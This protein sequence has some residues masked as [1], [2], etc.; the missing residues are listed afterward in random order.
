MSGTTTPSIVAIAGSCPTRDNFNSR[1]NPGYKRW[2]SCDLATNQT[3]MI[4]QMSPPVDITWQPLKK[5]NDYDVWNINS[6]LSRDF[7]TLVA[8][9]RP[10]YL[11][12]DFFADVH[13]GVV[14]LADGRFVTDNRWKIQYTDW[15]QE[16]WEQRGLTRLTMQ[17]DLEE[18]LELWRAAMDRFAAHLAE[19][20]PDTTVV[21]HRGWNTNLV[22][23]P[24]RPQPVLM[25]RHKKM[26]K[27]DAQLGNE[28]W[29][30]LDDYCLEKFGWQAIDLRGEGFTS[31]AEHPWGAFWVHYEPEYYHRFLAELHK[32]HVRRTATDADLPDRVEAIEDAARESADRRWRQAQALAASR[33][34]TVTEQRQRIAELESLGVGRAVKFAV[35]Q[36]LR[37]RKAPDDQG[38]KP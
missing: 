20:C 11:V 22:R 15:Y 24:E 7:L 14:R 21:V 4:A 34:E 19:H 32:I 12:L 5:M 10:Q 6:D 26:Q 8:E 30:I 13:F 18:Y 3:S 37:A 38:T 9:L 23:V 1:F 17:D 2:F 25:R 16:L 36:R 27:F 33:A 35:G 28:L 31:Y 29:A